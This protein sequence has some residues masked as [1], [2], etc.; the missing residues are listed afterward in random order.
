SAAPCWPPACATADGAAG[1]PVRPGAA[2]PARPGTPGQTVR[3]AEKRTGYQN[4]AH[5]HQ[6]VHRLPAAAAGL[7]RHRP[8]QPDPRCTSPDAGLQCRCSLDGSCNFFIYV[9]IT[10]GSRHVWCR[11]CPAVWLVAMATRRKAR[12]SR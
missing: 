12:L 1:A 6:L 5:A 8:D 9:A 2:Q 4:C 3:R 10:T 11:C 7:G